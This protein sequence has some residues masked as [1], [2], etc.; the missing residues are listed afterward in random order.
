[1]PRL[2][3]GIAFVLLTD[4]VSTDSEI[5]LHSL[6]DCTS[7]AEHLNADSSWQTCSPR[8]C[9]QNVEPTCALGQEPVRD[10]QSW[11][12][13]LPCRPCEQSLSGLCQRLTSHLQ[14]SAHQSQPGVKAAWCND[15]FM[16]IVSDGLPK[17]LGSLQSIPQPPAGHSAG[18]GDGGGGDGGSD[19][20]GGGDDEQTCRVRSTVPQANIYKVP[21]QAQMLPSGAA[22]VV[23]DPVPPNVPIPKSGAVG[24]AVDGVPFVSIYDAVSGVLTWTACDLDEC[25]GRAGPDGDYVYAGDP[26]GPTCLY[27]EADYADGYHPPLIG[28]GLDGYAIYGR[29]ISTYRHVAGRSIPLDACGGHAHPIDIA[30]NGSLRDY[31]H[32]HAQV[33]VRLSSTL[34][35]TPGGPYEYTAFKR[36]P[37]QCW[38]G[39]VSAVPQF[40]ERAR[41]GRANYQRWHAASA[42]LPSMAPRNGT[43]DASQAAAPP[44]SPPPPPPAGVLRLSNDYEELRPCCAMTHYIAAAGLSIDGALPA[45]PTPPSLPP[46][47]LPPSMPEPPSPPP[48]DTGRLIGTGVGIGAGVALCCCLLCGCYLCRRYDGTAEWRG[49]LRQKTPADGQPSAPC[50]LFGSARAQV[51]PGGT[52]PVAAE[53]AE[54]GAMR[55]VRGTAYAVRPQPQRG[56]M[57]GGVYGAGQPPRGLQWQ[58]TRH[59]RT[60]SR[61]PGQALGPGPGPVP[62]TEGDPRLAW[63][64]HQDANQCTPWPMEAAPLH[65]MRYRYGHG[66]AGTNAARR[67]CGRFDGRGAMDFGARR[68]AP[69]VPL[70]VADAFA[71][72][73]RNGSGYLDYH[74]L[75]D[76]LRHYGI[77]APEQYAAQV[78]AAFDERRDGKLDLGEF[79]QVVRDLEWGRPMG[80]EAYGPPRDGGGFDGTFYERAHYS[81]GAR[82]Q[83]QDEGAAF[84]LD[85]GYTWWDPLS[86][87]D[88]TNACGNPYRDRA[89]AECGYSVEADG[90]SRGSPRD[91]EPP[92]WP[93]YGH[94]AHK[95]AGAATR[96]GPDGPRPRHKHERTPRRTHARPAAKARQARAPPFVV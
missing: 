50:S 2:R 68:R 80:D 10:F 56:P 17:A 25:N 30:S 77:D 41:P 7:S 20:D 64:P 71:F 35:G 28:W 46:D 18:D 45:A 15:A 39:N 86:E 85:H 37:M 51:D 55:A 79:A 11:L 60:A 89:H 65:D 88:A 12:S 32:Y 48:N 94:A 34:V 22:N 40:W 14:P 67:G 90:D 49:G 47:P 96:S 36:G 52:A 24:V 3:L 95:G 54:D 72:Y 59:P 75:H 6:L 87:Q 93:Y 13:Q 76:A 33:E 61:R 42:T 4:L 70:R 8:L 81:G 92:P 74:E 43:V 78:V 53:A 23:S 63:R 69:I 38:A 58:Q 26:F 57:H 5:L 9:K 82:Q 21:L 91:A 44:P 62:R 84:Y 83:R 27:S 31:Y 19:S 66:P 29:H 73:D 16:V 1:M